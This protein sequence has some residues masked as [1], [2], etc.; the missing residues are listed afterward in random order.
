MARKISRSPRTR[1]VWLALGCLVAVIAVALSVPSAVAAARDTGAPGQHPVTTTQPVETPVQVAPPTTPQQTPAMI[2]QQMQTAIQAAS[3]GSTVGIDVVDIGSGAVLADLNADQQFYTASVVKLL[4]ALDELKSQNWQADSDTAAELTQMLATS[5]DDIADTLW[6][7]DGG[8]DIVTRM[9]DL[10][11]LPG[12]QAPEDNAQWG[13][14]LTTPQDVVKLLDYLND[15]VPLPARTLILS[16]MRGATQI[17]A[18]GTDQYFGIPDGLTGDAWAV[19]QGWMSLDDSTTLDTT[20]LVAATPGGPLRY[21]VVVLTTQP[22]DMSWSA[23]GAALTA[24]VTLLRTVI[25]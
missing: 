17:S 16:A 13:E 3:P 2:A 1:W 24:G 6:D 25:A 18:D 9:A 23:A 15:T 8:G 21:A 22:A 11:G 4:I 20:G 7:A 10:I 12:T 5:D 19:K 14:T